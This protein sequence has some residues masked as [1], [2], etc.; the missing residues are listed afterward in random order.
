MRSL[1]LSLALLTITLLSACGNPH[2]VAKDLPL[3]THI[4]PMVQVA[5]SGV[6]L[7]VPG[8]TD[9]Q[10]S[11]GVDSKSATTT[12][13]PV[14]V[15]NLDK[16]VYE[17]S[18]SF[19]KGEHFRFA[20]GTFPGSKGDC[21]P[22]LIALGQ[23]QV[24]VEFY[25]DTV[26]VFN[27]TLKVSYYVEGDQQNAVT[28]S[29]PLI[30]ELTKTKDNIILE[31]KNASLSDQN[32]DMG[33]VK[34]GQKSIKMLEITNSGNA[35]ASLTPVLNSDE[36]SFTGGIFPGANG[37]CNKELAPGSCLIEVVFTPKSKGER[38]ARIDLAYNSKHAFVDLRGSGNQTTCFSE[39]IKFISPRS[40]GVSSQ[41]VFPF[42]SSNPKTQAKLATLYGTEANYRIDNFYTVK[43]AQ[44]YVSYDLPVIDGT[45]TDIKLDLNVL[46]VIFDSY[47]DTEMLCLSTPSLKRC[48]GHKFAL[49]AW[50]M[51]L[52][53][54]FWKTEKAP[55]N[56][57][58]EELLTGTE[59]KCGNRN[60]MTF[61]TPVHFKDVFSMDSVSLASL[62]AERRLNII[63]SDDTRL[64]TMPVMEVTVKKETPCG[65]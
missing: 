13:N 49:E 23:C 25:S 64:L 28:L 59:K 63:I 53:K 62:A 7:S 55:I 42:V 31:V 37:T 22:K 10:L 60:C 48:S 14:I 20:G 26:G 52:N 2:L 32:L 36:F 15:T 16:V 1:K 58:Y 21:A 54:N 43:D 29:F 30:G 44:V 65:E 8:T 39:E 51:L 41:V 45:I 9:K 38:S 57:M 46:K 61:S 47:K 35:I 12:S 27:D 19:E 11:L 5:L 50:N 4:F 17:I 18:Y 40:K 34:L 3:E 56:E 33:D 24:D 6:E